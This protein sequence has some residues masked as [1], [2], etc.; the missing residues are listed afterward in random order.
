MSGVLCIVQARYGSTRLEGKVLEDLAGHSVLEHVVTRARQAVPDVVVATPGTVKDARIVWECERL[1]TPCFFWDQGAEADVL[2]RYVACARE[3][4]ADTIVRITADCPLLDA[5]WVGALVV[6]QAMSGL[7]YVGSTAAESNV[8]GLDCEVFSREALEAAETNATEA[9][10]REHVTEWMRRT[11]AG[12]YVSRVLSL[13]DPDVPP[14]VGSHGNQLWHIANLRLHELG[15]EGDVYGGVLTMGKWTRGRHRWTLDTPDDL[16][17]LR[18]VAE[19]I[20]LTPP[21]NVVPDLCALL[22]AHPELARYG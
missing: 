13:P 10:E 16:A 20:D 6:L 19:V 15:A 2:G 9:E 14:I 8:D 11:L 5:E 4:A 7:P 1:Q 18:K 3:R 12:S 22:T 17:W 21:R